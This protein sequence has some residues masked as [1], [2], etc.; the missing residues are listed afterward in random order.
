MV[1]TQATLLTEAWE[2]IVTINLTDAGDGM[3]T[4]KISV[5][6][7][8]FRILVNGTVN[9]ATRGL[10]EFQRLQPNTFTPA[11][12]DIVVD[13]SNSS[14]FIQMNHQLKIDFTITNHGPRTMV[15]IEA[16][17]T[18]GLV[19]QVGPSSSTFLENNE[20]YI[21]TVTLFADSSFTSEGKLNGIDNYFC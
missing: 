18:G 19:Y 12:A 5:P 6:D 9:E 14:S 2:P 4:G 10:V 3:F 16:K 7:L 13:T 20:T 8:P 15:D 1:L 21:V 11:Y 17:D